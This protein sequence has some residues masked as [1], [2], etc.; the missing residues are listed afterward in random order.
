MPLV[1]SFAAIDKANRYIFTAI[2]EANS[3][4]FA[5]VNEFPFPR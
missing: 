1:R 4:I 5:S 3:K 2:Y